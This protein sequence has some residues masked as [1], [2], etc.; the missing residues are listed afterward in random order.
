[1]VECSELRA[2]KM[3]G[4]TGRRLVEG[5]CRIHEVRLVRRAGM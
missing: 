2:A 3:D 5:G 1:M 4:W